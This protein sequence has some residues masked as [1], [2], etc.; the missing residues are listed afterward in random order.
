M[1]SL[2]LVAG[3]PEDD[4]LKAAIV[5]LIQSSSLVPGVNVPLGRRLVD[6]INARFLYPMIFIPQMW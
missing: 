4:L 2:P 5:P 3:N 1:I 6:L